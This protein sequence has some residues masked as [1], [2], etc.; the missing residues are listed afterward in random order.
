[1]QVPNNTLVKGDIIKL[2]QG[3]LAPALVELQDFE[4]IE[5]IEKYENID[6]SNTEQSL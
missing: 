2:Q 6:S 4:V 5:I 1:M 3:D